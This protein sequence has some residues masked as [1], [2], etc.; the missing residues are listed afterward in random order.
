MYTKY[1]KG[2][3]ID[4][5][6]ITKLSRQFSSVYS[7]KKKKTGLHSLTAKLESFETNNKLPQTI[8][9]HITHLAFTACM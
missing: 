1:N 3:K 9:I 2:R 5:I 8:Y 6:F 4:Q 7:Q